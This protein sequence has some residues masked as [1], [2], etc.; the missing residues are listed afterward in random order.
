L[1]NKHIETV[2]T[3][4]HVFV[5]ISQLLYIV[6]KNRCVYTCLMSK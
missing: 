5:H 2:I 6:S 1:L 4:N 3:E